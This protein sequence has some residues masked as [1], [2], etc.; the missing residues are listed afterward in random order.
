[1]SERDQILNDA[2][3]DFRKKHPLST[4]ADVR[5]FRLGW[6][7]HE[8]SPSPQVTD[9]KIGAVLSKLP[10]DDQIREQFTTIHKPWKEAAYKK[11]RNDRIFGAK[12][13]REFVRDL[14]TKPK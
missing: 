6:Y 1:M 14:L 8:E 7:A 10:S 11:V 5:T 9:E 3:L 2:I 12:W 13:M 4:P